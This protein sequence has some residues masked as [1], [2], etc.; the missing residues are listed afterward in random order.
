MILACAFAVESFAVEKAVEF[1]AV[2]FFVVEDAVI[3][4]PSAKGYIL[5]L[6]NR[7]S[8]LH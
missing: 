7:Q 4:I 8:E 1:S 3:G 6:Y 5:L 2:E